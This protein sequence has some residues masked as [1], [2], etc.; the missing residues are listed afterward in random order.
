MVGN[1][2]VQIY[3][4]FTDEI[5]E[6]DPKW[7]YDDFNQAYAAYAAAQSLILVEIFFLFKDY[8]YYVNLLWIEKLL[9]CYLFYQMNCVL[10][11][12]SEQKR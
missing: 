5:K 12:W 4:F 3:L 7:W 2:F 11:K 6:G 10:S 8:L 1:S 9:Q